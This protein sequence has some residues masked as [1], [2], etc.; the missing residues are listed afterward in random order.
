VPQFLRLVLPV[1]AEL[2]TTLS[3]GPP[4]RPLGGGSFSHLL[5]VCGR[6]SVEEAPLEGQR[7]KALRLQELEVRQWGTSFGGKTP[8]SSPPLYGRPAPPLCRFS[9][10]SQANSQCAHPLA[11]TLSNCV[12]RGPEGQK[13]GLEKKGGADLTLQFSTV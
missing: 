8:E 12:P 2:D 9:Q 4:P 1:S 6:R 10:P 5:T 13:P 3:L 11:A 7:Q